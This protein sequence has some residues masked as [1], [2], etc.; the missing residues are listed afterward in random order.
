VAA[1]GMA[2]IVVVVIM[3][4]IVRR[5]VVGHATS[6]AGASKGASP[7]SQWLY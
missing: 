1:M 2:V 5:V 6:K 3:V 7:M 4:M